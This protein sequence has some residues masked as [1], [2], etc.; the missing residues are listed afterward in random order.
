M[1]CALRVWPE[2]RHGVGGLLHSLLSSLCHPWRKKRVRGKGAVEPLSPPCASKSLDGQQ[3][4]EVPEVITRG[5]C[6]LGLGARKSQEGL[7]QALWEPCENA[8]SNAW[9]ADPV[10]LEC[11]EELLHPRRVLQAQLSFAGPQTCWGDTGAQPSTS[12]SPRWR[13]S[14]LNPNLQGAGDGGGY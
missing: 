6:C 14:S 12:C 7:L 13:A 3:T 2:Q 9:D 5:H 4:G 10:D 1:L 11:G 8:N